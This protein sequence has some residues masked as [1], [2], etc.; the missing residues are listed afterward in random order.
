MIGNIFQLL[1]FIY[2]WIAA[3]RNPVAYARKLGVRI[4]EDCRILTDASGC[5]GSE[6]YLV[7]LGN[8]VT[9]TAGVRFVTHDGGVWVFRE[10]EP[11]IDVLGPITVGNNVFFGF[12]AIILPGVSIGDNCVIGAGAVVARSIPSGSVAVGVPARP[13]KTIDQYWESIQHKT[14]RI[15]SFSEDKKREYLLNHFG[16]A[17]RWMEK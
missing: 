3:H 11:E 17:T 7:T 4:G 5:F 2:N 16:L 14:T 9:V 13:I 8:H 12:G 6:P 15:R 1:R 10:K